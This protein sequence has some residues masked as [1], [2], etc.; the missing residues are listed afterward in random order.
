MV[1]SL[2]TYPV[3]ESTIYILV[4]W[5]TCT[6]VRDL[7]PFVLVGMLFCNVLPLCVLLVDCFQLF[8][9]LTV[10]IIFRSFT[11]FG[12]FAPF[13]VLS[14]SSPFSAAATFRVAARS[15]GVSY[16]ILISSI[17][18]HSRCTYIQ[19]AAWCGLEHHRTRAMTANA[20]RKWCILTD[21]REI[22][23]ATFI[24]ISELLLKATFSTIFRCLWSDSWR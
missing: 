15:V 14:G 10:L 21:L 2:Y 22:V 7:V 18:E 5:Y 23:T 1:L 11:F 12:G 16:A 4:Y 13:W 3:L 8:Q 24:N 20:R 6:Q 9:Y 19:E 17:E